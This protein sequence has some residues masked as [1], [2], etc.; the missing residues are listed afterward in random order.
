MRVVLEGWFLQALFRQNGRILNRLA[1]LEDGDGGEHAP[2]R[3][4]GVVHNR[5]GI[6]PVLG[7]VVGSV[8]PE[9]GLPAVAGGR[10]SLSVLR[11]RGRPVLVVFSDPACGPCNALSPDLAGWQEQHAERLTIAVVSRGAVDANAETAQLHGLRDVLVQRDRE[12]AAMYQAHGT[13]SAV[14]VNVDGRIATPLAAG[15]AAI[16]ELVSS[17]NTKGAVDLNVRNWPGSGN[18]APIPAPSTAAVAV[19]NPVPDL[20]W[21]DL[22]GDAVSLSDFRGDRVVVLFWNPGCGFC[23]RMLPDLK[24]WASSRRAIDPRLLLISTGTIAENR[25]M[26]LNSTVVIEDS[27]QTR[28]ALGA[29]GTPSAVL[30]DA[31]G[32]LATRAAVG[33]PWVLE[34]LSAQIET[35]AA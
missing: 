19:G 20:G 12:V 9:F 11:E 18:A 34:L 22:N 15:A 23:S 35:V 1:S 10:L 14:L 2:E 7:L 17:G 27:L 25:V 5:D 21:R 13:P 6:R 29:S 30:I 32:R 33:A 8:A 16:T 24:A 31:D 4:L 26:Q 28:R 3:A